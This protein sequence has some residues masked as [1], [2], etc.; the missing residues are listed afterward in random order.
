MVVFKSVISLPIQQ[1]DGEFVFCEG[2]QSFNQ[3]DF[4]LKP[5]S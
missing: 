5:K 3:S 2:K 1:N 4:V